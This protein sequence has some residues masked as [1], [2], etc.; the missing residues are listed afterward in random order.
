MIKRST[1]LRFRRKFRRSQKQVENLS[2]QA[3][4][5]IE[6][7]FFKR[8]NRLSNIRRFVV[9][10]AMLVILLGAGLVLQVKALSPYYQEILPVKGG[11]YTEGI[12]GRFTT[13]NPLYA[14][15]GVDASVSRVLFSGLMR[16]NAQN[17]LVGDLAES[18]KNEDNS[19]LYTVVLKE[20]ILWHD[21]AQLTAEDVA[22]TYELI[23]NP[24]AKSPLRSNWQNITIEVVDSRTVTFTLPH[25][26]SSFPH[27]LTNGIVPQHILSE[28]P[29]SQLRNSEFN[30]LYPIGSGPFVWDS[31][32]VSGRNP[33]DRQEQIGLSPFAD[34]HLGRPQIDK[35]IIKAVHNEENLQKQFISQEIDAIAGLEKTPEN[36]NEEDIFTYELPLNAQVMTF[37][38]LTNDVLKE[39][40]V[41]QALVKATNQPEVLRVLDYPV[42]P[43]Q[44]PLLRGHL[45]FSEELKQFSFDPDD[46]KKILNENG[47][48]AGPDGIRSKDN[49][50]LAFQ[51]YSR[52]NKGYARIAET[53]KNQ[54]REIGAD[55]NVILQDDTQI[56]STIAL[57]NYDAL[58]YGITVGAD[59]DVYAYWHSTQADARSSSRLNLSEIKSDTLDSALEGGRT[60][61]DKDLRIA[62]YQPF[63]EEWRDEAPAVGLY[64]PRFLYLTKDRVFGLDSKVLNSGSDRFTDVHNWRIKTGRVTIE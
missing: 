64:Q 16:Y 9:A 36:V 43:V 32:Q 6:K 62:K 58:L 47:W 19:K 39:K 50:R 54:W 61:S 40:P 11:I 30:T 35:L 21:G 38:K 27:L 8:I 20:N 18:I 31:I 23:Q 12:L 29:T 52:D 4:Q 48:R 24:D 63:L 46:A 51:L 60:R 14:T 44:A 7:H 28:V 37:F 33:E 3:E 49:I 2:T 45:G 15:S 42:I 17:E 1:K 57:H 10:W 34:Y 59:P 5:G 26:L 13:T 55:V 22:F 25:S 53:L 41:R 56:Q